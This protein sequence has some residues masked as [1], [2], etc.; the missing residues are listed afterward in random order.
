[1]K[2][3]TINSFKEKIVGFNFDNSEARNLVGRSQLIIPEDKK[4]R[5]LVKQDEVHIMQLYTPV[6]C[7]DELAY[8]DNL[9][10]LIKTVGENSTE[11]RAKRIP[12]L[13]EELTYE[14]LEEYPKYEKVPVM[15]EASGNIGVSGAGGNS[16][17]SGGASARRSTETSAKSELASSRK[18]AKEA[19]RKYLTRIPIGI[20]MEDLSVSYLDLREETGLIIGGSGS[21]RSNLIAVALTHL[22]GEKIYLFDSN[23]FEFRRYAGVDNVVYANDK[24]SVG[25][26]WESLKE[27]IA[28]RNADH[29]IDAPKLSLKEYGETLPPT[30]VVIDNIQELNERLDKTEVASEVLLEAINVGMY[31]IVTSDGKIASRVNKFFDTLAK[32]KTGVVPGNLKDQSVLTSSG[33]KDGNQPI[34]YGWHYRKT[35]VHK[36]ML[37]LEK[38][39]EG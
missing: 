28:S 6:E 25:V 30:F 36:V 20:D 34:G 5:A 15:G 2:G 16:E 9:K 22:Q 10:E 4:G 8:N 33:I 31:V 11:E 35:G 13:P 32:N 3:S 19:Y 26:A 7:P 18:A 39:E 27:E 24:E 17:A 12:V 14:M 38:G 1:M 29:A 21:G 37:V 23:K